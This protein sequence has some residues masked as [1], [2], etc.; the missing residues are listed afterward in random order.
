MQTPRGYKV[1]GGKAVL[2]SFWGAVFNPSTLPRLIHTLAAAWIAGSFVV[3]GIAAW[4]L[5]HGRHTAFAKRAL[6]TGLVAGV[7]FSVAMPFLGHWHATEVAA[8]QPTKLAAF[9]GIYKTQEEAPLSLIGW[10]DT[11]SHKVVGLSIPSGLS[12]LVGGTTKESIQGL[13]AVPAADQPPEQ[14]T[15]QSYHWMVILGMLFAL[16]MVVGLIANWAEKLL[17]MRWLLWVLVIFIPLPI[18]ASEL[19][20]MSAE[21]GRQPWIVTGLMRTSDGVQQGRLRRAD[22]V[23]AGPVR[24]RVRGAVRRLAAYRARHDQAGTGRRDGGRARRR[25]GRS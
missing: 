6:K 4:Y 22:R 2:T 15:F 1:E 24:A 13:D 7:I 10:V 3:A 23:H 21:V 20:W 14:L 9:E 11:N 12:L 16:V 17:T 18:I 8:Q 25:R 19:G 5:L